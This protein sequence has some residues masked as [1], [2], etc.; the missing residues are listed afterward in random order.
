MFH[1]VCTEC[2][3]DPHEEKAVGGIMPRDCESCGVAMTQGDQH[4]VQEEEFARIQE[5]KRRRETKP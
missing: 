4:P 2:W 1:W 3:G 5:A